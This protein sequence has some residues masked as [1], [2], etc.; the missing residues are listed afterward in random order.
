MCS[1]VEKAPFQLMLRM[2]GTTL[3]VCSLETNLAIHSCDDSTNHMEV[4]GA[5][6]LS[7]V[8]MI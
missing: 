8:A 5:I 6:A 2:A 4:I 3:I 1:V 7:I